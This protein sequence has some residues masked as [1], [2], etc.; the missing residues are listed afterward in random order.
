MGWGRRLARERGRLH[1]GEAPVARG[2]ESSRLGKT[3]TVVQR[4]G[5]LSGSK[6]GGPF[7]RAPGRWEGHRVL[8]TE[9][10][11][12][13]TSGEGRKPRAETGSTTAHPHPFL[14]P[15]GQG[16]QTKRFCPTHPGSC[17]LSL[18]CC[19]RPLFRAK[20]RL[21]RLDCQCPLLPS[22][23]NY[24]AQRAPGIPARRSGSPLSLQLHPHRPRLA[25]PHAWTTSPPHFIHTA[26][27]LL[28]THMHMCIV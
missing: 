28:H 15:T 24:S 12:E 26:G 7:T 11:W 1:P 18:A 8:R 13:M 27:Q 23:L 25:E 3:G 6:P 16:N 20:S 4:T 22:K 21:T 14:G 2:A 10:L 19:A 5:V 17:R 9:R